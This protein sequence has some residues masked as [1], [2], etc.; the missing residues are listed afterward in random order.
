MFSKQTVLIFL[1]ASILTPMAHATTL[2]EGWFEI[3]GGSKKLGFVVQR[4]EFVDNKF[5]LVQYLKTT[6]DEEILKAESGADFAPTKY[7]YTLTGPTTK[8][9][10]EASFKNNIMN[11]KTVENGKTTKQTKKIQKGTFLATFLTYLIMSDQKNGGLKTGNIFNYYAI[12]EED[13]NIENGNARVEKTETVKNRQAFKIK[14][15]FKCQDFKNN[16]KDKWFSFITHKG[17]TLLTRIPDKNIDVRFAESMNQ[18]VLGVEHKLDDIKIV[19]A[20]KLPGEN[21][22]EAPTAIASAPSA[23]PE[24]EES[25]LPE[26]HVYPN[27]GKKTGVP[28]HKGLLFKMG[29]PQ[30]A[31]SP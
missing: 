7:T 19:F 2:F 8:K 26:K 12:A 13:G 6:E 29:A 15:G 9:F 21:K 17:E 4:Y 11:I 24:V 30:P 23:T 22:A 14:N 20:N 16:C 1:T 31:G 5:K 28:P 10:T 27:P 18:A 25:P 3:Y